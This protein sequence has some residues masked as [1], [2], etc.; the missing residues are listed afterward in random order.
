MKDPLVSVI[1]P[2]YKGERFIA[3]AIESV[4]KQSYKPYE[5]IV[6]YK[7]HKKINVNDGST[8]STLEIINKYGSVKCIYQ[9]NSGLSAA[10]NQGLA[11]A[12]GDYFAFLDAD[13]I[14]VGDKLIHQIEA[15]RSNPELDIVFGHH[16][17]FYHREGSSGE[18]NKPLPALLKPAMLIK[19]ES[20]YRVGLFDESLRMGDFLDWYKRALE[21][22][23]NIFIVPE[24]VF[25]RRIHKKNMTLQKKD[26][27]TDYFKVLKAS[28]D[29]QRK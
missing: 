27:I 28:L 18:E 14:W 7:P 20:F 24:V 13:D 29:R 12:T 17:R 26:V 8:D 19:R 2:V 23:L 1:I 9:H 16:V 15:F 11:L 25:R 22:E 10:L 6:V 3:E 5:I 21:K 4:E